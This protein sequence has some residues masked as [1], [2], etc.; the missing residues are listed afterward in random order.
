MQTRV[1]T[2]T[3]CHSRCIQSRGERTAWGTKHARSCATSEMGK[4][5]R[6][7]AGLVGYLV[8]M[9]APDRWQLEICC[10]VRFTLQIRA[11]DIQPFVN[12]DT[13]RMYATSRNT[14]IPHPPM[15][16]CACRARMSRS[17]KPQQGRS[18]GSSILLAVRN[19][20]LSQQSKELTNVHLCM[21]MLKVCLATPSPATQMPCTSWNFKRAE[22]APLHLPTPV[23]DPGA[24][25]R[26][27][28][29]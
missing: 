20:M 19:D 29:L 8:H 7:D 10:I 12:S 5:G 14:D 27:V 22:H 23:H 13:K 2:T 24:T 4:A 6:S 11:H 1:P 25:E 15:H 16:P 26:T 17:S 3:R 21:F 18:H 28:E 9:S